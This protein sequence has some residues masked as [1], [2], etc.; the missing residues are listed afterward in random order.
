[1][2][3]LTDDDFPVEA[4]AYAVHRRTEQMPICVC[5]DMEMAAEIAMRLSRDNQ[6]HPEKPS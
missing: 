6:V 2:R 4:R 3:A 5:S 1:M